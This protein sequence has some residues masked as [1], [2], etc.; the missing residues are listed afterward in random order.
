MARQRDD[1]IRMR[2]L[3]DLHISPR[4]V[5][6][7]RSHGYDVI[8]VSDVMDPRSRDEQIV[9]HA[10]RDGRVILTQDLDYSAIIALSG[11]SEPSLISL[12]LSSARVEYVSAVLTRV[13]P[14][15]EKDVESG[16]IIT[17]SDD[18]IRLRKLPV[19]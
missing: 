5:E 17:V 10:R 14:Q 6:Q 9:D 8:R 1:R 7:L 13:L 2:L 12:R 3:A 16:A 4:T 19:G 15:V 18:R 11:A